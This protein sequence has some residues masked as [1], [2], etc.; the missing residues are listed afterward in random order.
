MK[1]HTVHTRQ[2]DSTI[3]AS[4]A[5]RAFLILN[6]TRWIPMGFIGAIFILWF[7]DRGIHESTVMI[8]AAIMGVVTFA[9]ELPTSG[10]ADAIGRKPLY[11]IASAFNVISLGI[12]LIADNVWLFATS[13]IAM[14]IFRALE[15]GPLQAWFMDAVKDDTT[16]HGIDP[17]QTL[18]TAGA[19]MGISM[20]LGGA[21]SAALI[22]LHPLKSHSPLLIPMSIATVGAAIHLV[23]SI[24]LIQE[25]RRM[26]AATVRSSS[27]LSQIKAS[28]QESG[29][30]VVNGLK[31]LKSNS[32]LNATVLAGV[33]IGI[34]STIL[35][36]LLPMRF[37]QVVGVKQAGTWLSVLSIVAWGAY[38]AGAALSSVSMKHIGTAA[39]AM[40]GRFAA[41]AVF[42]AA[43]LAVNVPALAGLY[44]VIFIFG[45]MQS[46]S[47][48]ALLNREASS[49]NRTVVLSLGSMVFFLGVTTSQ[50]ALSTVIQLFSLQTGI[51]AAAVASALGVFCY[52]PALRKEGTGSADENT[53][54]RPT[55]EGHS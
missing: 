12:L 21:A 43:G 49:E 29:Q 24:F 54:A 30:N 22:W 37:E 26:A 51:I 34:G 41:A 38:A 14:G 1:G 16:E 17:E 9:L 44:L 50:L 27:L 6:A 20:G 45:G 18:G 39:T 35:E 33:C 2:S 55:G 4:A 40:F 53:A 15:S 28:T 52:I 11:V 10:L 8:L 19:V 7:I 48:D 42:V 32:T 3:K 13:M 31:L 36:S 47:H 23:S 5:R 25:K 46:P